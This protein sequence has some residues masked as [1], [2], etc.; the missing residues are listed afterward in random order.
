MFENAIEDSKEAPK[1][2]AQSIQQ[3]Q[4]VATNNEKEIQYIQDMASYLRRVVLTN[5]NDSN[6]FL[7]QP[8]KLQQAD[9]ER[10]EQHQK[11]LEKQKSEQQ[12]MENELKTQISSALHQLKSLKFL[13]ELRLQLEQQTRAVKQLIEEEKQLYSDDITKLRHQILDQREFY[14][15]DLKVQLE[16]ANRFAKDFSDLH[17]ELAATKIMTE[18][19]QNRKQLQEESAKAMQLIQENQ[20]LRKSHHYYDQEFRINQSSL[21]KL[22]SDYSTLKISIMEYEEKLNTTLMEHKDQLRELKDK[23]DDIIGELKLRK[24]EAIQRKEQLK[25]E[26]LTI[27]RDLQKVE[28]C[29]SESNQKEYEVLDSMSQA[30]TFILT[31]IDKRFD[32][33]T[34]QSAEDLD[35][36]TDQIS[37][38]NNYNKSSL[39][40]NPRNL[41]TTKNNQDNSQKSDLS[42]LMLRLQT[43]NKQMKEDAL[44]SQ[45]ALFKSNIEKKD[46]E[47]QTDQLKKFEF[48]SRKVQPPSL[49][50]MTQSPR[51][52]IFRRAPTFYKKTQK[53][54]T[55]PLSKK[56]TSLTHSANI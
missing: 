24:D 55:V 48:L 7:E 2:T 5:Q 46:V 42:R 35:T 19:I 52:R 22:H 13:Q 43:I 15:N 30:A 12:E 4:E 49:L 45:K 38:Q 8:E 41:K 44:K 27:Q 39:K 37:L 40:T 18:T 6:I 36:N 16:A 10:K 9:V 26:L 14:E 3:V 47:T 20:A 25:H 33:Q 54:L 23:K 28:N 11:N 31:A 17:M 56:N 32:E 1:L 53:R 29:R 50:Q 51:R 21:E 34:F